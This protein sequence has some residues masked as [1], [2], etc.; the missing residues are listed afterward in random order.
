[1]HSTLRSLPPSYKNRKS[2]QFALTLGITCI[3]LVMRAS[4]VWVRCQ[5]STIM[6]APVCSPRN[7]YNPWGRSLTSWI[8]MVTKSFPAY[9]SFK[10]SGT[11]YLWCVFCMCRLVMWPPS[12]RS[13]HWTECYLRWSKVTMSIRSPWHSFRG[14][15]SWNSWTL[16]GSRRSQNPLLHSLNC[17]PK[18]RIM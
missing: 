7:K 1:M 6:P 2:I 12:T 15:N 13:R 11:I 8:A 9:N 3:I 14:T 18:R 17:N 10:S 4:V 5:L 16:M